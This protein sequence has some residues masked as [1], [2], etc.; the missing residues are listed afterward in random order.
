MWQL[1]LSKQLGYLTGTNPSQSNLTP[2][3]VGDG[4]QPSEINS[5]MFCPLKPRPPDLIDKH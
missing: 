1:G 3:E 4:S 5:D 2:P